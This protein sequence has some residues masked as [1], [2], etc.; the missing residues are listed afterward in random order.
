M[1]PVWGRRLIES[2]RMICWDRVNGLRDDVG[3]EDFDEVVEIFLEEMDEV[4]DRLRAFPNPLTYEAEL[5]FLKGSALNLGF[6]ALSNICMQSEKLADESTW[7]SIDLSGVIVIYEKSKI[8]FN[9]GQQ[10][11][12]HAA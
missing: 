12:E 8:E 7:A 1:S 4:M 3:Q 9:S 6:A 2:M 11:V 10:K 5:H